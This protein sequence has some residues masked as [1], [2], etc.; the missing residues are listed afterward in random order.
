MRRSKEIPT[1]LIDEMILGLPL[2]ARMSNLSYP[3]FLER[4]K[5]GE[6]GPLI[7]VNERHYGLRFGGWKAAMAAREV[8][9]D[10]Y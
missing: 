2:L 4:A 1:A 7:R 3:T 8:K 5:T 6:F 9:P 10:V